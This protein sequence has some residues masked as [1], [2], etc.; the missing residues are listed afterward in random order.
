MNRRKT[1]QIKVGDLTIG[2]EHPI[3][4]QSMT[5]TR[6]GDVEATVDQILKLEALGCEVVRV[7]VNDTQA[8]EAISEIKSRIHIPLVADIHFDYRLALKAIENGID[9]LRINPGNIGDESRIKAVVD[10]CKEKQIPIRIGVNGGSLDPDIAGL[11]GVSAKGLY[12]SAMK[13][14]RILESFDFYDI[15]ISI[16]ASDIE[17]TLEAFKMLSDKV[18]YPFHIGITEA[19]TAFKGTIKSSIGLGALLLNGL[20]DTIRVSL[21]ADPLEEIPVCKEILNTLGLRQFGIK[22]ISCPTCGR[23]Q[24]Q[25]IEI[26]KSVEKAVAHINKDVSVAIMGCAVN[27]PGEAREADL[28]VACGKGS[29]LIFE[30]GE[31]IKKVSEEEIV[32]T[33]VKMIEEF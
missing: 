17:M 4:I 33:L 9:K 23:T 31:I 5:N 7:T 22:F 1:R 14:I 21:T 28:G 25:M 27:G 16:K 19:G 18:D 20:G 29:G 15:I 2:S 6:T 32:P 24:T 12:E 11:F 8:A 10:A 3:V 13:H 30:K 26:A